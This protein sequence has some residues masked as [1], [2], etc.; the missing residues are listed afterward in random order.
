MFSGANFN[1]KKYSQSIQTWR[2]IELADLP[3]DITIEDGSW[4][5]N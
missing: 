1:M 5:E 3:T 2:V 4:W